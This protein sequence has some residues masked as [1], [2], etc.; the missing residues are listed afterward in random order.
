MTLTFSNFKKSEL[1]TAFVMNAN[2]FEALTLDGQKK[3][4]E[5]L[6]TIRDAYTGKRGYG[7]IESVMMAKEIEDFRMRIEG[8]FC[9]PTHCAAPADTLCPTCTPAEGHVGNE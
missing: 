2:M 9:T 3:M 7:A 1:I 4:V 6:D 8:K 5:T